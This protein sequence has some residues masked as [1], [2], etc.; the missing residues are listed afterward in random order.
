MNTWIWFCSFSPRRQ[1]SCLNKISNYNIK[2][3]KMSLL[4]KESF[5]V[6]LL[7]NSTPRIGG[8]SSGELVAC[9]FTYRYELSWMWTQVHKCKEKQRYSS[10]YFIVVF[11]WFHDQNY[12][13]LHL[14]GSFAKF[15]TDAKI[16]RKRKNSFWSLVIQY[17]FH[18]GRPAHMHAVVTCLTPPSLLHPRIPG[19]QIPAPHKPWP[20]TSLWGL[21]SSQFLISCL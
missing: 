21:I 5:Q 15:V 1:Y 16:Y 4:T 18:T 11:S 12:L 7:W 2:G 13:T 8:F 10:R 3:H 9:S 14:E 6:R 19:R 17:V 20:A